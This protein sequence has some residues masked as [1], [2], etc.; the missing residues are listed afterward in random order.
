M[1]VPLFKVLLEI[2]EILDNV[3]KR[4]LSNRKNIKEH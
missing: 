1:E 2:L 4:K 3:E